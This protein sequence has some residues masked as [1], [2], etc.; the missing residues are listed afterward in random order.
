[1]R[2]AELNWDWR[3]VPTAAKWGFSYRKMMLHAQGLLLSYLVFVVL[4]YAGCLTS[5]MLFEQIWWQYGISVVAMLAKQ[6]FPFVRVELAVVIAGIL[7]AL[8]FFHYS[9]AV[10][11]LTYEQLRGDYFYDKKRALRFA[12]RHSRDAVRALLTLIAALTL[13]RLLPFFFGLLGRIP[14]VGEW[15]IAVGSL[16]MVPM[17]F[18][19]LAFGLLSVM[20][21]AGLFLAPP[22]AGVVGCNAI[23]AF[24]QLFVIVWNEAWRLL[25]YELLLF[26]TKVVAASLFY[27]IALVGFF[28][29]I[30]GAAEAYPPFEDALQTAAHLVWGSE[31]PFVLGYGWQFQ[32]ITGLSP[33]MSLTA[34]FSALAFVVVTIICASF[35]LSIGS[36]GNTLI[37][38]NLR[39]RVRGDNVLTIAPETLSDADV[40][41]EP[42]SS[43]PEPEAA[44]LTESTPVA[45][46][47]QA[48]PVL[49]QESDER[50]P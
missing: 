47:P 30:S 43:S 21:I 6:P 14:A 24:Y 29:V 49:S 26:G 38:I 4:F 20:L 31:L 22:I 28:E 7:A 2:P 42:A 46:P 10:S 1:M 37:Y 9:T 12:G 34:G 48:A 11:K 19:G 33:A 18:V 3:D 39:R 41:D 36:V 17:F 44:P 27:A 15:F 8:I 5:G 13:L 25:A 40:E 16:F 35:V 23:E 45:E 32:R 50:N